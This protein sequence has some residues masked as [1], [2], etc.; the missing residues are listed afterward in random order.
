[1]NARREWTSE[2]PIQTRLA[3]ISTVDIEARTAEV[4]W[5]TGAGVE[6]MD[7][8]TGKHFIE[9]L[10]L[11]PAHVD[12]KR[13]NAGAPLLNSHL[14]SDIG[15]VL[16][17]VEKAWLEG[18]E[19]RAT[20]RFSTRQEVE[21]ILRDV[22][23]GI[24][25]NVS[26]GYRVR[27]YEIEEREGQLPIYRAVSWTPMEVSLV[28]IG[29]DGAAGVRSGEGA[30]SSCQFIQRREEGEM[31]NENEHEVVTRDF[32]R[33]GRALRQAAIDVHRFSAVE[34]NEFFRGADSL[35]EVRTRLLNSLASR[36]S[37][38]PTRS[39]ADLGDGENEIAGRIDLM[40]EALAS[41][42]GGPKPCDAA[43]PFVHMRISDMAKEILHARGIYTTGLSTSTII[44]RGLH[45]TS[46]FPELLTSAGNRFLRQAYNSYQGGIT[47]ICKPSTA[48]DF[49]AKQ[50]LMISEAPQLLKVLEGGEFKYGTMAESKQ[51]Y[52]LSTYGRIFSIT[53]QALINDDLGAFAD[54]VK[55]FGR[56]AAEFVAGQLVDLLASN[57][58]M[59]DTVALFDAAHGNLG[60]TAAISVTSLGEAKKLMRLQKG[61]DG[62]TPIDAT[63]KYLIVPA[64][65][66]TIAE[67]YLASIAAAKAD[68]S[69]P[70][71]GRLELVVDP[72]LDAYSTT[73]WYLAA[74]PAVIDTIEYSY[75]EGFEGPQIVARQG[76]HIDGVET[77]CSIDFG[78]GV[79]DH[80]GLL[81]NAG[82]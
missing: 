75:L 33:E 31:E 64:T 78:A 81:K 79:L 22:Q 14:R 26:V 37:A 56:T 41:R 54:M 61:L 58:T 25:R 2:L 63:P 29:A 6:R 70:F 30:S 69:N 9:E 53:R 65:K 48:P 18:K 11:D 68:D 76:F 24:I 27:K 49:R 12:L 46:D 19:A 44:E 51:S 74:D 50:R 62:A 7:F 17:V 57:P 5:S 59:P 28:P 16:G 72:R 3:P 8:W 82:A 52:S 21:P 55:M 32:G 71:S 38:N 36:S 20:V 35:R 73:A 15:D 4:V 13:L 42:Y 39:A 66:E 47:R 45:S 10:S 80:R 1:M 23:A 77:K 34:A 67:Q 40:G 60:T 43:R